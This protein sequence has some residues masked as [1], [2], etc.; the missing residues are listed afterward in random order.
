MKETILITGAGP[1]GVTGRRIMDSFASRGEYEILAPSSHELDLTDNAAVDCYFANHK[2]DY[3]IHS[4]VVYPKEGSDNDF[5]LNIKM[6]FNLW[7]H[8][9]SFKK[10]IYF[11]SGAEYDKRREIVNVHEEEIGQFIPDNSY[12]LSKYIMNGQITPQIQ[13]VEYQTIRHNQ[14]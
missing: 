14:P 13:I 12:G 4:A 2:M 7:S 8:K 6:F 9:A 5:Y 11:G 10:M 3:I 1:N